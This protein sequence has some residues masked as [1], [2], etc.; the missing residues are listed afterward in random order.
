MNV[1]ACAHT[2][3]T[4]GFAHFPTYLTKMSTNTKRQRLLRNLIIQ[5]AAR[6]HHFLFLQFVKQS[7]QLNF[8]SSLW[9]NIL[10][11]VLDIGDVWPKCVWCPFADTALRFFQRI[12]WPPEESFIHWS[13]NVCF[14]SVLQMF[15]FFKTG[16]MRPL[17]SRKASCGRTSMRLQYTSAL[18]MRAIAPLAKHGEGGV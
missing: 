3:G 10:V 15:L 2:G 18:A 11:Q 16:E 4:L 7:F 6:C 8:G 13:I 9:A 14:V 12:F 5:S 1:A 17:V